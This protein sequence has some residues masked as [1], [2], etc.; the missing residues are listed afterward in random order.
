MGGD[1]QPGSA[2]DA[3]EQPAAKKQKIIP[4]WA[5]REGMVLTAE[6]RGEVEVKDERG[7]EGGGGGVKSEEG[8]DVKP[9]VSAEEDAE[10]ARLEVR[11]EGG[12]L[13][14]CND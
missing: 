5:R 2:A 12:K 11:D 14:P 3:S 13:I 8:E 9:R 7:E 6:Q 1:G 10:K 4:E